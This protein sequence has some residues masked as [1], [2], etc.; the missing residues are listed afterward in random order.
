MGT[1]LELVAN[2]APQVTDIMA[3]EDADSRDAFA[4]SKRAHRRLYVSMG[5]APQV[6]SF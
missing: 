5:T 1:S 3:N 2:T 4:A 6:C